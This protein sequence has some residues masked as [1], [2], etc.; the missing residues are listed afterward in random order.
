MT[1]DR[2][3]PTE[4]TSSPLQRA[5]RRIESYCRRRV[6]DCRVVAVVDRQRPTIDLRVG[7]AGGAGE[8][9]L[10]VRGV[11]P[12]ILGCVAS[13][14]RLARMVRVW[15]EPSSESAAATTRRQSAVSASR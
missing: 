3:R 13:V 9:Q 4:Q 8:D 12:G 5:T 1:P 2:Q 11:D 14:D 7:A 15:I 6:P 10:W